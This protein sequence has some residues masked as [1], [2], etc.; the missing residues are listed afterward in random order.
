ME[1]INL[2]FYQLAEVA[3][4]FVFLRE[5]SFWALG[6]VIA[7]MVYFGIKSERFKRA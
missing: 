2:I 6:M 7:I 4:N 1:I 3:N 5:K